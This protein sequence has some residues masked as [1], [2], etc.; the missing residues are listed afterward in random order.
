M[1]QSPLAMLAAIAVILASHCDVSARAD[2]AAVDYAGDVRPILAQSCFKCHAADE[3]KSGLRLD[4]VAAA[5]EGGNSGPAI[6]AGK[7]GESL[8]IRALTGAEDVTAMP[9]EGPRL[10]AVQIATIERWI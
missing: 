6:V 5:L 4:S 3:Q 7:S 2:D 8:L 1:K 10:S 9:P